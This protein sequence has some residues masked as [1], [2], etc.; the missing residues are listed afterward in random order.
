M[1]FLLCVVGESAKIGFISAFKNISDKIGP[2]TVSIDFNRIF[3]EDKNDFP[4][5]KQSQLEA[6][7]QFYLDTHSSTK[8]KAKILTEIFQK[9][10]INGRVE[11]K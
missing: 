7:G 11:V 9:Y 6:I 4:E 1:E 3:K 8:E 10:S 5:Y 2:V